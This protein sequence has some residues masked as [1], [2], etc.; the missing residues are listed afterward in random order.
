LSYLG[1]AAGRRA[2]L[3]ELLELQRDDGGWSGDYVMRIPAPNIVDARHVSPW[4][5]GTGGGNS[6]VL[7][8]G[9]IFASTLA[10]FAL[11]RS[12]ATDA[13]RE[14]RVELPDWQEPVPDDQFVTLS[15]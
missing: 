9:G 6:Y 14:V 12:Q 4:S 5:R 3:L 8:S 15:R 10:C 1:G 2:A 11:R 13:A 7:D